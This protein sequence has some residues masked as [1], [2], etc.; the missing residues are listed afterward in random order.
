MM[1]LE[2]TRE[3][4]RL[5]LWWAAEVWRQEEKFEA[6]TD[7]SVTDRYQV[8]ERGGGGRGAEIKVHHPGFYFSLLLP[9]MSQSVHFKAFQTFSAAAKH[10]TYLR[11]GA[12]LHLSAC[13]WRTDT[14]TH[15]HTHFHLTDNSSASHCKHTGLNMQ[16]SPSRRTPRF[17]YVLV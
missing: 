5:Q 2:R 13:W 4:R 6:M 7:V 10:F 14:H 9:F 8:E 3:D 16:H 17:F 15:R 1:V 11:C 12:T